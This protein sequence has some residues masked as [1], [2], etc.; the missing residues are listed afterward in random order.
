ML[1]RSAVCAAIASATG[2][3]TFAAGRGVSG[4]ALVAALAAV[5]AAL[6]AGIGLYRRRG[7]AIESVAVPRW[8]AIVSA[9]AALLALAQVG[10]LTVYMVD[11]SRTAFSF[12][13]S[14]QW[15]REHSCLTAYHVAAEASSTSGIYDDA[16]Y[17]LPDDDPTG[18]RKARMLEAFKVD[19]FEYPPPFLLLP[20]ALLF[21][22]PEFLDH[23]MLWFALCGGLLLLG[24]VT[25]AARLGPV[26]G[27]RAL[28]LSPFVWLAL[29][30]MS[31]LQKGNVQVII[32]VAAILAMLLFEKR[33][34]A[35]GGALLAFATASKL[36]PGLLVV[37]LLAQRRFRAAAWT[38]AWGVAIAAITLA[39]FGWAPYAGFLDHLPKLL[40][41]E[42]FPAFRN[43]RAWAINLSIPG[44]LFKAGVFGASRPTF[45]QMKLI[46]TAWMVVALAATLWA[47]LRARRGGGEPLLWMAVI[48]LATLR[49]PF[50]PNAYGVLPALWLL[51][52]VAA[53]RASTGSAFAYGAAAW[54]VL[55]L[56]WPMDWSIDTRWLALGS[57]LQMATML[58]LV[59]MI[60]RDETV[61]L[62]T[63]A[64]ASTRPE[65]GR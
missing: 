50:L 39:A 28:L 12:V 62:A 30:T 17:S 1:M 23:R 61:P 29:P 4:S 13:P 26:Q 46:G 41:G 59:F 48:I 16:L 60:I 64:L 5:G 65:E 55:A 18:P 35:A 32:V 54:I 56:S 36:Y 43:P 33:R 6:L 52:L 9:V 42:S 63:P 40:S 24:L 3:F 25:L 19:V 51:T 31:T 20:R 44:L 7:F 11:S 8:L 10:R 21:L 57:L 53:R 34:D 38:A 58:G 47:A 2:L 22:T 45:D 14:S 37:Y 49:S 27:T 15:E